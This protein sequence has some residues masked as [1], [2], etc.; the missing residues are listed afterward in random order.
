MRNMM[1]YDNN[2]P[3][4]PDLIQT[5]IITGKLTSTPKINHLYVENWQGRRADLR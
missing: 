3:S 2:S 1:K 5:A 4:D